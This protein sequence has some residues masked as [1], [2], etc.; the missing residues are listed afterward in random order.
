MEKNDWTRSNIVF[1]NKKFKFPHI[2]KE[3]MAR[4]NY[5]TYTHNVAPIAGQN[6]SYL[7]TI[8]FVLHF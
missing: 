4:Q 5:I 2:F 8:A 6:L 3:M 1:V 7:V